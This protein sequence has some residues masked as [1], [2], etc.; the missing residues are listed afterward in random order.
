[1]SAEV[2]GWA[3]AMIRIV[4]I[5]VSPTPTKTTMSANIE[6]RVMLHKK[7]SWLLR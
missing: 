1:M 2:L 5:V 3:I 6:T 4:A 7:H